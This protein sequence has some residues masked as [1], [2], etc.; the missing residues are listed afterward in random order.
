MSSEPPFTSELWR[1]LSDYLEK[2]PVAG[3]KLKAMF[4]KA[5]TYYGKIPDIVIVDEM[6]IPQLIIET[7]RKSD[8]GKLEDLYEPLGKA[9]VAQALCYAALALEHHNLDR[10]P[11]FA[12]ANR[13]TMVIF[14]GI[15]KGELNGFVDIE[16]CRERHASPE[17]WTKALKLGAYSKLLQE[18]FLARLEK[19]L[20][21]DTIKELFDNYV[22]K[23]IIKAAITPAQ[24]YRVLVDQLRYDIEKLHDEYVEDAVKTRV[25]KDPQYFGE[26]HK[27]ANLQ[28]YVNGVLSPGLLLLCPGED[29]S[30]IEKVCRPLA[31]KIS[32]TFSKAKDPQQLFSLFTDIVDKRIDELVEYCKE[33]VKRGKAPPA[34]CGKKVRDVVS[35]RNLS[36][37]MTYA[38]ATKILAYKVLELHYNIPE[39][40]PLDIKNLKSSDDIIYTLNEYFEE[41]PKR[42]EE[43]LRIKDF[44]PIFETGLYDKIVFKG[45]EA[46]DRVNALIEIAD[47]IKESLK[48]LPGVIG[49]VYEGFIPPRERHQLGEFYTP[50]AV[51][52]LIARWAI[53]SGSD[54]VLDGGCGSGTFLIEAYKRFLL[55]KFNKEYSKSYPTCKENINEHQDILNNLYGVD[56]NA[57]A[58]QL[59]S[60]HLMFM[61]PRCPFS[62]LNIVTKDFFSIPEPNFSI[63]KGD[64]DAVI[65][66]PPYTRWTE[67]PK[68]TKK[69]IMK[70]VRDLMKMYDLVANIKRGREPGIYVYWILHATKNLLKNGG[71]L[72]MI[73]SNMWLQTDYGV[74]FGRFLL[75]NFRIK[76]LIDISYRLFEALIST[77]I[78][79]AEKE[80]N[81]DARNNNEVLLVRIPPM[82]SQLCEKETKL[83]DREVETKIDEALKCI[84]SAITPNYEFDK[85]T[86]EVCR[87]SYGIWYGFIKQSE[88]PRDKKWISLFFERVEDIV[89]TLEKHPLMIRAEEWFKPSRGNSVWS[90]WALDHSKR[91]DLG[92][93]EFFYF[94]KDKIDYWD[95]EVKGFGN[96]VMNYLVPAITTSK[97]VRTFTFTEKDW[98]EIRDRRS[99]KDEKEKYSDAW[100]LVLHGSRD[101]V[102]QSLQEYI[103]WGESD[104]CKTQIRGTRGG[105]RRCSEA[106]ACRA[107]EEAREE[108]EKEGR[109]PYFYGW[110]DLGGYI[111]TPIMTIYQPR[112]HPQFFLATMPNLITYHAIIT[113]IPRIRV[114]LSNSTYDPV[115]FNKRYDNIIDNI[116]PDI[117]LDEV[118]VK[119]LLAYLNSTFNWLWLEQNARYIAKGPLGLEVNVVKRMPTLNVKKVDRKYVEEL[120]QLFNKLESAIRLTISSNASSSK[121]GEEEEEGC[122]KLRMFKELRPI[123][124]EIDSKIAEI[125]GIHVDVDALWDKA[126]EMMERRIKGASRKVT[127]GVEEIELNTST[128]RSR[129]GKRKI[130]S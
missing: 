9:V 99:K 81:E 11:L 41:A 106:V 36:R 89:K 18:Y 10:T 120:A 80:P 93:K 54:K 3:H 21:E 69:L 28:G 12:T 59:T 128:K 58:T 86:L 91:P 78:V 110:Y 62:R 105:G 50:P 30:S 88:I 70:R 51:A 6:K 13:D 129:K 34:T 97:N 108:A 68:E 65:G 60:L 47:A 126:W 111:P 7:K 29:R 38:L 124:R 19:P 25:L 44:T 48:L 75:D 22:A 104:E 72:G 64:F 63:P 73:I 100:I 107:R 24:L 52:R 85:N 67:I 32:K 61:E 57:F 79:L 71:R 37:M 39:L 31:E 122:E 23:W 130:D 5:V 33:G 40:T 114:V 121:E 74:D 1:K 43:E 123:F 66:N 125:L 103:R 119:A 95:T 16:K 94:S 77:V 109:K 112:Y 118:E 49:Y 17:D 96:D 15:E 83:S 4:T 87:Q 98:E 45:L 101:E 42:I 115:E 127:P 35:F 76:A 117:E 84:E 90:I 116:R 56:I 82:D 53:R 113:L 8:E 27:L 2:N 20:S 92:A 102:P 26:L 46:T 14:K 55:L